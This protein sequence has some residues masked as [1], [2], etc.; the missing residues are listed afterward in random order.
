VGTLTCLTWMVGTLSGLL[1]A[2]ASVLA[3][4]A[5][6]TFTLGDLG[7]GRGQIRYSTSTEDPSWTATLNMSACDAVEEVD[8]SAEGS[9]QKRVCDLVQACCFD[10][11]TCGKAVALRAVED[12]LNKLDAAAA[13]NA[14]ARCFG[15]TETE[16]SEEMLAEAVAHTQEAH[17]RDGR[18]ES[19]IGRSWISRVQQAASSETARLSRRRLINSSYTPGSWPQVTQSTL[20]KVYPATTGVRNMLWINAAF[21]DTPQDEKFRFTI[22]AGRGVPST[23]NGL[24]TRGPPQPSAETHWD[25]MSYASSYFS[26]ASRGALSLNWT[27]IDITLSQPHPGYE[28]TSNRGYWCDAGA[29]QGF[30]GMMDD[31][32]DQAKQLN[33]DLDYTHFDYHA[34]IF[35]FVPG[36]YGAS[37][38][39]PGTVSFYN[40]YSS[41]GRTGVISAETV[42]HEVGHNMGLSHSSLSYRGSSDE[43]GDHSDVM[44]NGRGGYNPA[45]LHYLGWLGDN[46]VQVVRRSGTYRIAAA[47]F[48]L[49]YDIE[50][51]PQPTPAQFNEHTRVRSLILEKD[52]VPSVDTGA[53]Q[54][55]LHKSGENGASEVYYLWHKSSAENLVGIKQDHSPGL[56]VHRFV[57]AEIRYFSSGNLISSSPKTYIVDPNND[58]YGAD[59]GSCNVSSGPASVA[60]SFLAPGSTWSSPRAMCSITV[61]RKEMVASVPTLVVEATCDW[62]GADK[63]TSGALQNNDIGHSAGSITLTG[64][65]I[66]ER[67]VVALV[68]AGK[69]CVGASNVAARVGIGGVVDYAATLEATSYDICYAHRATGGKTDQD[70]VKQIVQITVTGTCGAVAVAAG[71]RFSNDAYST[72]AAAC[73]TWGRCWS[74]RDCTQGAGFMCSS[75]HCYCAEKKSASEFTCSQAWDPSFK[76][77]RCNCCSGHG[78]LKPSGDV[79]LTAPNCACDPGYSGSKCEI[80]SA[81]FISVSSIDFKLMAGESVQVPI[82]LSSVSSS[83]IA[84]ACTS[85]NAAIT[86]SSATVAADSTTGT[87]TLTAGQSAGCGAVEFSAAGYESFTEAWAVVPAANPAGVAW[88]HVG[89]LTDTSAIFS[90][91]YPSPAGTYQPSVTSFNIFKDGAKVDSTVAQSYSATGLTAGTSMKFEVQAVYLDNLEGE[92]ATLYVTTYATA[93]AVSTACG[94][95]GACNGHGTCKTNGV[96]LCESGWNGDALCSKN[97]C[98]TGSGT[99]CSGHGTCNSNNQC[100][101]ADGYFGFYCGSAGDVGVTTIPTMLMRGS[102][103]IPGGIAV[104]RTAVTASAYDPGPT[105]A[106][107]GDQPSGAKQTSLIAS[108]HSIGGSNQENIDYGSVAVQLADPLNPKESVC[109]SLSG[110][111]QVFCKSK[112]NTCVLALTN[113]PTSSPTVSPTAAPTLE[114]VTPGCIKFHMMD[115]WGDGW[116]SSSKVTFTGPSYPS[117]LEFTGLASGTAGTYNICQINTNGCYTVALNSF[118]YDSETSWKLGDANPAVSG[119]GATAFYR[120]TCAGTA[121][122]AAAVASDATCASTTAPDATCGAAPTTGAGVTTTAAP[123]TGTGA[124][125]TAAPTTAALTTTTA[126]P[127]TTALTTTTAAPTTATVTTTTAAPT[128]AAV[129]T[130]TAAPTTAAVATTTAAPTTAAVAATTAAPT[131]GA[132]TTAAPTPSIPTVCAAS[133]WRDPYERIPGRVSCVQLSVCSIAHYQSVSPT[134]TRD[135]V[136]ALLTECTTSEWETGVPTAT[137]DRVCTAHTACG[138]GPTDV[139]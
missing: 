99:Q 128:T 22:N 59:A 8:I 44:G 10:A 60:A 27:V 70:F 41:S 116:D 55:T 127:T 33:P 62:P 3:R 82:T 123:T 125:T 31:A 111:A 6:T 71:T 77:G 66:T 52:S 88:L 106:H 78:S 50:N 133:E 138:T 76:S 124:T 24:G 61:L 56:M 35:P 2:S 85:S 79:T 9:V 73:A 131:V 114:A 89:D 90:W 54:S 134:T 130:T 100:T 121:S 83:A 118:E 65:A 108:L 40:G 72:P 139:N 7:E 93:V 4:N 91:S 53:F 48:N 84:V 101:C 112:T 96:C 19:H 115:S 1:L 81:K 75:S 23:I 64:N 132:I 80:S 94:S 98:D 25:S 58:G 21:S 38:A 57:K 117:G 43:Y 126:A 32:L 36:C 86:C 46:D 16:L 18:S 30:Y 17:L 47:D 37:G 45:Y 14:V 67:D 102:V 104:V 51:L 95:G 68:K 109:S 12:G 105:V 15:E 119:S 92:M 113:S 103:A 34:I 122:I 136:C 110:S 120:I 26:M 28:S 87:V 49:Q 20:C 29:G 137:S 74:T 42:I 97:E 13:S 5:P 129:T 135:R 63:V 69:N 39:T 107:Q 11:V